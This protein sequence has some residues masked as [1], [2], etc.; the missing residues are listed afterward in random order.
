MS[1]EHL[2]WES[3]VV[4]VS[5]GNLQVAGPP[6]ST[7]VAQGAGILSSPTG[8]SSRGGI[9][10]TTAGMNHG[11]RDFTTDKNEVIKHVPCGFTI[12]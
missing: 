9:R 12:P 10:F 11:L 8:E 7:L 5:P 1:G 4:N 6:W 2:S 3:K